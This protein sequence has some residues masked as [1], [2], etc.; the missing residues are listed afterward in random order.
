MRENTCQ[1]HVSN[2]E[3]DTNYI[4]KLNV[5]WSTKFLICYLLEHQHEV[6]NQTDLIRRLKMSK[7]T[8][9]SALA[10]IKVLKLDFLLRGGK[11]IP[12]DHDNNKNDKLKDHDNNTSRKTIPLDEYREITRQ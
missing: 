5:T 4:S 2:F 10:D 7:K 8:V 11:N 9:Q 1:K 3:I 12:H 6:L